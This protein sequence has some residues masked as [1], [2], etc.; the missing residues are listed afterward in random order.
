[1]RVQSR[2]NRS[3]LRL[4]GVG[5]SFALVSTLPGQDSPR[6]TESESREVRLVRDALS[7]VVNPYRVEATSTTTGD[8]TFRTSILQRP[9][10]E[11]RLADSVILEEETIRESPTTSRRLQKLFNQSDRGRVLV[12]TVEEET[13]ERTPGIQTVTRVTSKPD[14]N[15]NQEVTRREVEEIVR[16]GSNSSRTESTVFLPSVNGGF[17]SVSQTRR[18]ESRNQAGE[19]TI[20]QEQH[21]RYGERGAWNLLERVTRIV[22]KDREVEEVHRLDSQGKLPLS[23]RSII[24]RWQD[25]DGQRHEV[26]EVYSRNLQGLPVSSDSELPLDRRITVRYA[27]ESKQATR[28]V[29]EI[30]Q[31]LV[32]DPSGGLRTVERVVEVTSPDG[33]TEQ[34]IQTPDATGTLKTSSLIVTRKTVGSAPAQP[35]D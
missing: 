27:P 34:E 11:G 13:V 28:V 10:P 33:R 24:R 22:E 17:Q 4:L 12:E 23:Q 31:R 29:K 6:R 30:E 15:G 8:R 9:S 16:S 19:L 2:I 3:L 32:A 21:V 5:V 14:L 35:H 25:P 18:T 7:P 20:D 1:M 26:T